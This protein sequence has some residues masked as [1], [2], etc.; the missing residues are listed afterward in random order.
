MSCYSLFEPTPTLRLAPRA[1]EITLSFLIGIARYVP[2]E[3]VLRVSGPEL[4]LGHKH[5]S[6][7]LSAVANIQPSCPQAGQ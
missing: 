6:T 1:G 5:A 3:N 2:Q 4:R 7:D